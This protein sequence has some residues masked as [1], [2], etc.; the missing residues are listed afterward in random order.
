MTEA[1]L[2]LRPSPPTAGTL[3]FLNKSTDYALKRLGIQARNVVEG[4]NSRDFYS[5]GSLLNVVLEDGPLTYGLPEEITIW[6]QESPAWE[7]DRPRRARAVARYPRSE[8]LASGW[9]LG[10][11]R[12]AGR[13]AILEVSAGEWPCS[14]FR[15]AASV[16]RPELP[17]I[18]AV[19]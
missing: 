1:R 13:A 6:S 7:A 19:F 4:V 5:P 2:H 14:A 12:I 16:P 18:Q 3:I 8:I 10:E 11:N 9:L 17:D 15:H